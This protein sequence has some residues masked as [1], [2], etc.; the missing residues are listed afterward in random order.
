MTTREQTEQFRVERDSMGEMQVPAGA[1]YGASTARAV[2]NFPI[3]DLRFPPEFIRALGLIKWAA[4]KVNQELGLLGPE[5][6]TLIE[7]AAYEVAE[8][9]FADQFPIDIFQTGSG[10]STNM[11]ANEVIANRANELAGQR[12]VHPNDDV[13]MGQSSNDVIPTAIH[14]SAS[15]GVAQRLLPAMRHLE[16]TLDRRAEETAQIAKMGRT[17]LMDAMPVMLGQEVLGWA[18]QV[19]HAMTGINHVLP[20]LAELALG[21]TAVGTGINAH[22]EFASGVA[23]LLAKQTGLSFQESSNHFY[24]QATM[25]T[26]VQLSGQL[27]AYAA[28]LLKFANDLRWMNSG[29]QGGLGEIVLPALQP[30]SSIMPGKINPVISEATMMVCAQV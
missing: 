24:A 26:A 20:S 10:T 27:K 28:G 5:K 17:H 9:A 22:P 30:G 18:G 13:N 16:A 12:V 6:A 4:A 8:G 15:I 7:Q 23:R 11:N 29:P 14:L 21:G 3:S 1:R 2:E 25:D 19:R